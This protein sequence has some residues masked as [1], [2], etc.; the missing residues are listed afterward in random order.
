MMSRHSKAK[1][2]TR[3]VARP[4]YRFCWACARQLHGNYHRVVIGPDG[5]EHIVHAQCAAS[6]GLR[7]I[8]CGQTVTSIGEL[9]EG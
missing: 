6:D 2:P 4:K 9:K 3:K 1:A 7:I 5:H 8:S